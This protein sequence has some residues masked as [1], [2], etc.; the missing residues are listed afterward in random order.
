MTDYNKLYK[1]ADAFEKY[2][3]SES[4]VASLYRK[5]KRFKDWLGISML[6]ND[7][8]NQQEIARALGRKQD[9]RTDYGREMAR[10]VIPLLR[11]VGLA[12][13][14]YFTGVQP[15]NQSLFYARKFPISKSSIFFVNGNRRL[16]WHSP[17]GEPGLV[18]GA[19]DA[20]K[21]LYELAGKIWK[22]LAIYENRIQELKQEHQ[23][24]YRAQIY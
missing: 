16:T 23:K 5:I 20:R 10:N 11:S 12:D 7:K 21:Q 15:Y 24:E 17:I 6:P 2:A 22:A 1:Q 3:Q 18:R 9:G 14:D 13:V 8:I 19:V 4:N